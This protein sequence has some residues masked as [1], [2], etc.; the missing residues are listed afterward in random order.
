MKEYSRFRFRVRKSKKF[1]PSIVKNVLFNEKMILLGA[2]NV[3]INEDEFPK[4][5]IMFDLLC[6]VSRETYILIRAV[7]QL[8]MEEDEI[9]TRYF[10]KAKEVKGLF[11][12]NEENNP[13]C[14][15]LM[16][17]TDIRIGGS[18]L[19]PCFLC[20]ELTHDTLEESL[21]CAI[22]KIGDPAYYVWL[23]INTEKYNCLL[24][25]YPDL[26][27]KIEFRAANIVRIKKLKR[28]K[29]LNIDL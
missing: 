24:V 19:Y 22:T 20:Q 16:T 8:K 15:R 14:E 25:K 11:R 13:Y 12:K 18:E 2:K 10:I 27:N 5:M 7:M 21:K 26:Q 28:I 4:F 1:D 29:K 9:Y 6:A 17:D 3:R 23:R